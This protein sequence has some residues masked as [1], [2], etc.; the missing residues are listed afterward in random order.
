MSRKNTPSPEGRFIGI[1]GII[2]FLVGVPAVFLSKFL[3][4]WWLLFYAAPLLIWIAFTAEGILLLFIAWWRWR[5]TGIR[6]VLVYADSPFSK[7]F[8]EEN[9]LPRFLDRVVVLNW[10][11]RNEWKK[12]LP[13]RLFR[14]FG[15]ISQIDNLCPM[16]IQLRG[17]RYPHVYRYRYAF[18]DA[19]HENFEALNRLERQMFAQFE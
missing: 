4:K 9:W 18:R 16:L 10:S 7:P 6:G 2:A 5:G 19:K 17:L 8:I 14:R 1:V 11:K 13:V 3:N 15:A 12:S